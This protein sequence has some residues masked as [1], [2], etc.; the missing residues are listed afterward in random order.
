MGMPAAALRRWHAAIDD[1]QTLAGVQAFEPRERRTLRRARLDAGPNQ[2]EIK[3]GRIV[4]RTVVKDRKTSIAMA[5]ESQHQC[6][7]ID[8]R[9]QRFRHLDLRSLD[10]VAHVHQM[11]ERFKLERGAPASMSA[12]TQDLRCCLVLY[13]PKC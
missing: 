12:I 7:A 10:E 13:G 5:K 11:Q 2:R 4:L 1:N 3:R 6:R 8:R 9:D